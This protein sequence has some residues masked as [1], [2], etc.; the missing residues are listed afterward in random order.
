MTADAYTRSRQPAGGTCTDADLDALI[1]A[2]RPR[3]RDQRHAW[4]VRVRELLAESPLRSLLSA[5]LQA[6]LELGDGRSLT[7]MAQD[8]RSRAGRGSGRLE[9]GGRSGGGL[10]RGRADCEGGPLRG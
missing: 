2:A 6:R 10:G 9:A 1:V 8:G 7:R 3:R 4:A 5:A